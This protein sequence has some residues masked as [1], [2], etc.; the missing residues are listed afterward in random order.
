MLQGRCNGQSRSLLCKGP[1]SPPSIGNM[2][3]LFSLRL[4]LQL[5]YV[6]DQTIIYKKIGLKGHFHLR[7]LKHI[8]RRGNSN[9]NEWGEPA[10]VAQYSQCLVWTYPLLHIASIWQLSLIQSKVYTFTVMRCL[11]VIYIYSIYY[12]YTYINFL[13]VFVIS[14]KVLYLIFPFSLVLVLFVSITGSGM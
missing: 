13:C 1:N 14:L 4:P 9:G 6:P 12:T 10:C 2:D 7:H 3:D 8:D 11:C 5:P